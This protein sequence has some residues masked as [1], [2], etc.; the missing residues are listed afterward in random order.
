M[1]VMGSRGWRAYAFAVLLAVG[2]YLLSPR[3]AWWETTFQVLVGY[4]GVGAILIGMRQLQRRSRS[5]WLLLALGVF[6]SSSA[7]IPDR[8]ELEL[9]PGAGP[10]IADYLYLAFYPACAV[11]LVLMLRNLRRRPDRAA[12]T[13]ALTITVGIGLLAW[14]YA[15]QPALH[16]EV[17][18]L[19]ERVVRVAY[20][21]GDLVLLSLTILLLRTN[22]R[23]GGTAPVWIAVAITGYLV[24]DWAWVVLGTL[25]NGWDELW[26]TSR[27]INGVY[28]LSLAVLGLA[29]WRPE[30]HDDGPGAA[31]IARLGRTHL[32]VLTAAV[33][34]APVMLVAEHLSGGVTDAVAIAIGSATMFL[35]VVIRMA[36]LLKQA[37]RHS[38]QVRELSRRDE[39]TGLPNR[40]AWI[41]ELPRVLEQ[42]RADGHPVSIAMLDLDRFKLFN[43]RH[44]HP[45]GDRLLKEAAAA[46]HGALRRSDILARYGGEEFI[47]LLP[48]AD[49]AQ[50]VAALERV[51]AVTPAGET[52]SA[53]VAT[54]NGT[55]T[56]DDLITRADTYLYAAKN[57]G[58]DRILSS[59][60]P[61][62]SAVAQV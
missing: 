59:S 20:P 6:C 53:G 13:D 30:L 12:L 45:A 41:D 31:A 56:S 49:T 29:A 9:V 10:D 4:A 24:G 62:P 51:R 36:Q 23:R 37:E 42:A 40:R 21:I 22:G 58:R 14:V 17:A 50:A 35:L 47:A 1:D 16:D 48:G 39:L 26:W 54:W 44:G 8:F 15:M 43:D 33:L 38:R 57:A 7:P 55:E 19:S 3:T 46:W 27:T 34:I 2:L 5:P 52:F 28:M 11:A 32:A 25:H 61:G 18:S 60:E